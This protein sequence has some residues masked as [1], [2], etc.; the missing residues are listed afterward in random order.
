M[1][2]VVI[3]LYLE[4]LGYMIH[5]CLEYNII[6]IYIFILKRTKIVVNI[7]LLADTIKFYQ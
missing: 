7:N 5:T 6:S 4:F 2:E 1:G 3:N